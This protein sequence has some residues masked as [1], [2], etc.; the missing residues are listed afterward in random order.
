MIGQYYIRIIYMPDNMFVKI[1]WIGETAQNLVWW[2]LEL[3]EID[4]E[5]GTSYIWP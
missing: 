5:P 2:L 1:M 3:L 4:L